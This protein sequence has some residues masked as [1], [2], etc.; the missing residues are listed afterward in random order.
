MLRFLNIFP[1][2]AQNYENFPCPFLKIFHAH[3]VSVDYV[4][5][6]S[7]CHSLIIQKIFRKNTYK[8]HKNACTIKGK[9]E[10]ISLH[11]LLFAFFSYY[12]TPNFSSYANLPCTKNIS[13][14][15][16]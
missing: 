14:G 2:Y 8:Q 4:L 13:F 7:D 10:P 15:A 6:A 12:D 1:V 9:K 16:F 3:R 11:F 5:F